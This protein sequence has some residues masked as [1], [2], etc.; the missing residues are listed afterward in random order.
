MTFVHS[1]IPLIADFRAGILDRNS[2][3]QGF[4]DDALAYLTK[5]ETEELSEYIRYCLDGGLDLP[6][7]V[8]CYLTI[9]DDTFEEQLNFMR[10]NAYRHSTFLEVADSVYFN[11]EYM[12]RYMHG[13]ALTAFIWPNHV[14]IRRFFLENLPRD[15]AGHYLEIGPGHG[16]FFMTAMQLGS[17]DRFSG[18][19]IS[20]ASLD[21]TRRIIGHHFPQESRRVEL[22]ESDFLKSTM[23]DGPFAAIVMGEVLEHVE[24]PQDFLARIAELA[25]PDTYI[26]VTTCIN[27]PAIDHIYLYRAPEEVVEMI[28]AAGLKVRNRYTGAYFGKS[29]EQS[30]RQNLPINIA[31]VLEKAK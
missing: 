15:K 25:A 18:I 14:D 13:L 9:L 4:L 28:E 30:L 7:L 29:L 27:A 22:V 12:T 31:F 23:S 10:T 11:Q 17:F 5:D 26:F 19:D 21:L 20:K 8:S 2:L 6:E 1:N 24:R 3:H 16:F